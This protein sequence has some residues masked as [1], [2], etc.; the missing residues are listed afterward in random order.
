[1]GIFCT[2]NGVRAWLGGGATTQRRGAI[3]GSRLKRSWTL[4]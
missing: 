4:D 1:M 2:K 3:L